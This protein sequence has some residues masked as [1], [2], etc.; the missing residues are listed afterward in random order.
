MTVEVCGYGN[1]LQVPYPRPLR[2]PAHSVLFIWRSLLFFR[3]KISAHK[4]DAHAALIDEQRGEDVAILHSVKALFD[5]S[6]EVTLSVRDDGKGF[7]VHAT[8]S[9]GSGLA[10]MHHRADVIGATLGIE[11]QE[12]LGTSVICCLEESTS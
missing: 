8:K 6:E 12:G 2:Y 4:I 7:N 3:I 10:I 5:A 1:P 9:S 11:S